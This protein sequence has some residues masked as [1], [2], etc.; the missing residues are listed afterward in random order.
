MTKRPRRASAPSR[1]APLRRQTQ[2]RGL[3]VLRRHAGCTAAS[4]RQSPGR[5][6]HLD[7]R[8]ATQPGLPQA[9]DDRE[10]RR[11]V[12]T[13]VSFL[14][15]GQ[16]RPLQRTSTCVPAA[17]RLTRSRVKRKGPNFH[18]APTVAVSRGKGSGPSLQSSSSALPGTSVAPGEMPALASSQ[19]A[20]RWKPSRSR[21]RSTPMTP[22]Q[23][24]STALS[25][26]SF[27]LG[28]MAGLPSLQSAGRGTP[29][30]SRSGS[31]SATPLQSSS[32]SLS[33]ISVALGLMAGLPSLQSAGRGRRHGLGLGPAPRRRCSPRRS[34][35]RGSRW[36]L[37]G[38]PRPCRCSRRRRGS[39][40]RPCPAR[41]STTDAGRPGRGCRPDRW[42]ARRACARPCPTPRRREAKRRGRTRPG[43]CRA[44]TR[45]S[46]H[47]PRRGCR[48][49]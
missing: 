34:R 45:T 2:V 35:C 12:R 13:R 48:R 29:S 16:P 22:S 44:G 7:G 9:R 18:D 19:S 26:I 15:N 30:R 10:L 1:R 27:A 5:E 32:T 49:R 25:R 6:A 4:P 47:S 42:R 23:F 17:T 28:L 41:G 21:S 20:G 31:C 38:W 8:A 37:G 36:L 24:S 3:R 14:E 46:A 33:R 11:S 40:P 39:C 43:R